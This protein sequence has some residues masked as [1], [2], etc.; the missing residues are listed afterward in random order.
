[1]SA[2]PLENEELTAFIRQ[3]YEI[4]AKLAER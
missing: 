2:R 3:S 4:A 1:M